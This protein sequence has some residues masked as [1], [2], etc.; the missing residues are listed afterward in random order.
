MRTKRS[1]SDASGKGGQEKKRRSIRKMQ[2]VHRSPL[3]ERLKKD[4]PDP[5]F[6]KKIPPRRGGS[7]DKR[8]S[9][10]GDWDMS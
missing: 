3:L 7:P 5:E 6:L 8:Y 10:G 9:S 4:T 1:F 2:W